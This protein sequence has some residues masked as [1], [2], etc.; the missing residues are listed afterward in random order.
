MAAIERIGAGLRDVVVVV[1]SLVAFEFACSLACATNP[2]PLV[3]L[4][5][6]SASNAQTTNPMDPS[7]RLAKR[8]SALFSRILNAA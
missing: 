4:N 7:N 2:N 5:Y 8:P 1:V 3:K 6:V